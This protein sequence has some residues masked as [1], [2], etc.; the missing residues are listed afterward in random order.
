MHKNTNNTKK[1]SM[2][3]FFDNVKTQLLELWEFDIVKKSTLFKTQNASI[4]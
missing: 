2:C 1:V 4:A 3:S